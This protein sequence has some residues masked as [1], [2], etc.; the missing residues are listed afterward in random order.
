MAEEPKV[1]RRILCEVGQKIRNVMIQG[2]AENVA[3]SKLADG[4]HAEV[5]DL[6]TETCGKLWYS[7]QK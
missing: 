3:E 7:C 1:H 2:N 5:L 6:S 4:V